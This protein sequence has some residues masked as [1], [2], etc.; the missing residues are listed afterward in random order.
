MSFPGL[1]PPVGLLPALKNITRTATNS[2]VSSLYI[3]C[4]E[5]ATAEK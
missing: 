3:F 4:R 1:L 5:A 2:P